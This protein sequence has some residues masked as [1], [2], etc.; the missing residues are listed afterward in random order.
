[1]DAADR[2]AVVAGWNYDVGEG[3]WVGGGGGGGGG[4]WLSSLCATAPQDPKRVGG[5]GG[6]R[7]LGRQQPLAPP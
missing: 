3:A 5:S 1:M 2:A 4:G 6:G 7:K